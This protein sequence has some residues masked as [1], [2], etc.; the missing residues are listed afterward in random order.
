MR[1]EI[2]IIIHTFRLPHLAVN[3]KI[4]FYIKITFYTLHFKAAA[5][6]CNNKTRLYAKITFYKQIIFYIKIRFHIKIRLYIFQ[7]FPFSVNG[8]KVGR[9]AP[10]AAIYIEGVTLCPPSFSLSHKDVEC[11]ENIF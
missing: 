3:S 9:V 5:C 7:M 1:L 8:P 6:I 4:L 10:P 11:M 2:W